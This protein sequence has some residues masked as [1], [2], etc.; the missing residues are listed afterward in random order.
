M[1]EKSAQDLQTIAADAPPKYDDNKDVVVANPDLPVPTTDD[2]KTI[3]QAIIPLKK[4]EREPALV[5][6]PSCSSIGVTRIE[7]VAGPG[8]K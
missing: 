5:Q 8:A 1:H 7:L 6:C 3:P 2:E 4:L